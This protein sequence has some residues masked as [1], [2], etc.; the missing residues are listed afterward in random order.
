[1]LAALLAPAKGN[2]RVIVGPAD[3]QSEH[4]RQLASLA[5][6]GTLRPVI[7]RHHEFTQMAAAHAYVETRRKRGS[8]VVRVAQDG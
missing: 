7:D 5:I 4:L 3:V 6:S 2:K 8:V 1:M